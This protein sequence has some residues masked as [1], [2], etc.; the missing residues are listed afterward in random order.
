MAD[1]LGFAGSLR[2]GSF[3]RALLHAARDLSPEG[4]RIA[5]ID[6]D[7]IPLYNADLDTDELRPEPVEQLKR[8]I[9]KA[10]G[11]LVATPEYN[12]GMSGV[13]KNAIDWASRPGLESVLAGKP[14][15]IMGASPGAIGTARAQQALKLTLLSTLSK[16][17]PHPGVLVNRAS[18]KFEQGR[19][20][21]EETRSFLGEF[22]ED[23]SGW[24]DVSAVEG[25]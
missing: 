13:L 8:R 22:L 20:V 23:L 18:E 5:V 4:M 11:L 1:I 17:M 10:D 19:L 6:L 24:V 25:G 2:K 12:H 7:G 15:A 16:V 14:V 9:D 21:H 3:N